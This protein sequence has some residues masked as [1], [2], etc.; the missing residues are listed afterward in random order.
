M[1]PTKQ[2]LEDELSEVEMSIDLYIKEIEQLSQ[3]KKSKK[4]QE[5]IEECGRT[6]KRM[7]DK[8]DEI[9]D[10]IERMKNNE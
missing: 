4:R 7:Y 6:L 3:S 8:R 10:Q 5:Q 1:T 2:Q 9:Q